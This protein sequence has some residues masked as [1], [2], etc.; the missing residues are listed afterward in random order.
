MTDPNTTL[1]GLVIAR[2]AL[3]ADLDR[4]GL[5]FCCGGHQTLAEAVTEAGLDLDEVVAIIEA[6]PEA[7]AETEWEGID[8][9]VDHLEATHHAYLNDAL[10]ALTALAEKVTGVHGNN[11]PE[12]T[13]VALLV[14][15]IR[16]DLEPHLMKEE[17]VLF[18]MIRELAA[19]TEAP[20]FHCGSLNNPIGVM[21]AE[22]DNAG[23]LLAELRAATDGY[24]VPDDGC[25]SY[26]LLYEGLAE[27]EA[28]T[29]LHIHEENNQLFPAVL[30]AERA[31]GETLV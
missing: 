2:P 14:A 10:P 4:L 8:G 30:A 28:D 6:A 24:T 20:S 16:A 12:L 9:L 17:R 18:P 26:T 5:D 23:A 22:H 7:P 15:E 1:G 25:A 29:H 27:L 13:R 3:A 31:I 19:A 11:H 21:L